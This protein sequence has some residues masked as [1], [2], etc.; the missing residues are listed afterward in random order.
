MAE[1]VL[2]RWPSNAAFGRTVPKT[3]FYDHG[4]FRPGLRQRFVEELQR[5][6]W[7][8]KL[9]EDTIHLRGTTAVPEIQVFTVETKGDDASDDVLAAID[10]SVHFPIIFE[11]SNGEHVRTVAT[12][13]TLGGTSPKVGAYFTTGW[14]AVDAPRRPL[15]TALDLPSLYEALLVSLLPTKAHAG[16][17]VS[18][19][20]DRMNQARKLQ[21]EMFALE[22]KL[23]TEPQ[24]N[25]KIELRR[26]LRE[27]EAALSELT[28]PA[29]STRG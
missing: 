14:Q 29:P 4:N 2:Y 7:T 15:P 6:T 19:A 17:T 25:R 1:P 9:A 26:Q 23:R 5:I 3:K 18:D 20:T 8:Y 27:R 22:K 16:E 24:L 13:K 11:V 10:R 21:R 12:L 28:D